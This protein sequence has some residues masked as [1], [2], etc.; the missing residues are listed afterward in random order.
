VLDFRYEEEPASG[1][2]NGGKPLTYMGIMLTPSI[3]PE[4]GNNPGFTTFQ[5]KGGAITNLQ[6][7][8]LNLTKTYEKVPVV[9]FMEIKAEN[10]LK[11]SAVTP[12]GFKQFYS[13]L[14]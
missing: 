4:F 5:V 2:S 13:E 11:L 6:F 10:D 14:K 12:E 7:T 8:F 3:S 9:E 1:T